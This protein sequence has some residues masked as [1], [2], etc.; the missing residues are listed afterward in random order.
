MQQRVDWCLPKIPRAESYPTNCRRRSELMKDNN[1]DVN[2]W[3]CHWCATKAGL[4]F[5]RNE[6]R[7][8]NRILRDEHFKAVTLIAISICCFQV[9]KFLWSSFTMT[10]LLIDWIN[11]KDEELVEWNTDVSAWLSP[12]DHPWLG[13]GR[14]SR[15]GIYGCDGNQSSILWKRKQVCSNGRMFLCCFF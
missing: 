3:S 7:G 5:V 11:W 9:R 15:E 2:S 4:I 6:L 13:N 10:S 8:N 1:R 14:L 12:K